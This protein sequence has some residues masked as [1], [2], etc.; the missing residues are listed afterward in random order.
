MEEAPSPNVTDLVLYRDDTSRIESIP[1]SFTVYPVAKN[2]TKQ[3]K[4]K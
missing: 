4:T 3:D 1:L 2:Q